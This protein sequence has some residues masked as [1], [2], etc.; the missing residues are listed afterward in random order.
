[1][2]TPTI[3]VE[4]DIDTARAAYLAGDYATALREVRPLAE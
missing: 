2:L 3:G 1:M 4:Q